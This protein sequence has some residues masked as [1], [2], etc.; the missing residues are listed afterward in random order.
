MTKYFYIK[1][2]YKLSYNSI[3]WHI[4]GD[5]IYIY[6]YIYITYRGELYKRLLID[7]LYLF[8]ERKNVNTISEECSR[9]TI[10]RCKFLMRR[11]SRVFQYDSQNSSLAEVSTKTPKKFIITA[12]FFKRKFSTLLLFMWLLLSIYFLKILRWFFSIS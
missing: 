2:I 6:I 7:I 8:M 12:F 11:F 5:Y 4:G 10:L 1:L 9:I 3:D